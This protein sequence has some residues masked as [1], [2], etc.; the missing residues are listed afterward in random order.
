MNLKRLVVIIAVL[1]GLAATFAK[2]RKLLPRQRL[3]CNL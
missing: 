1:L 3:T 2:P